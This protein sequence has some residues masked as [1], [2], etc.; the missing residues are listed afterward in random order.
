MCKACENKMEQTD[1][2]FC[3]NNLKINKRKCIYKLCINCVNNVKTKE[4]T[5]SFPPRHT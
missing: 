5:N 3:R 4:N 2:I 1:R